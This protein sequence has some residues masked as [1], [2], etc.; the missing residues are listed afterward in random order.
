MQFHKI[1]ESQRDL[2]KVTGGSAKAS[3]SCEVRSKG[4][5][6]TIGTRTLDEIFLYSAPKAQLFVA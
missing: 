3:A 1:T 6:H 4:I 5:R 2:M